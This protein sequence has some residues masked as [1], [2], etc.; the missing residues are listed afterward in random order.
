MASDSRGQQAHP[1]P[2]ELSRAQ[3]SQ[4]KPSWSEPPLTNEGGSIGH[5]FGSSKVFE[6]A[7]LRKACLGEAFLEEACLEEASLEEWGPGSG[8]VRVCRW[9]LAQRL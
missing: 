7:C 8:K 5:V 2:V 9:L 1:S 3:P 6:E 4:A